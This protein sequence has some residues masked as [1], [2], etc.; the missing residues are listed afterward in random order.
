M[1]EFL[2]MLLTLLLALSPWAGRNG[3]DSTPPPSAAPVLTE[4]PAHTRTPAPTH[5]PAPM[6]APAPAPSPQP[7]GKPAATK[8]K[9]GPVDNIN[10]NTVLALDGAVYY[11][12]GGHGY[13]SVGLDGTELPFD[14]YYG[15]GLSTEGTLL[16]VTWH[17]YTEQDVRPTAVTMYSPY[18]NAEMPLG[19][20]SVEAG[21]TLSIDT[22]NVG[23]G[24]YELQI[25]W[26]NG[27]VT[28]LGFYKNGDELWYC[29]DA[30]ESSEYMCR[31]YDRKDAI[32]A[33]LAEQGVTPENSLDYSDD[34][35]AYPVPADY[36][37]GYRC[38]N[39]RWIG[40]AR[41]LA[42]DPSLPDA[43]KAILIHDWM[44]ENLAYDDYKVNCLGNTRA[45]VYKDYTG[46]YSM[47]DTKTGVCADFTTVY[48]IML[49]SLGIPAVSLDY[50]D[51]HV[52]NVVYLDGDWVEID[53]TDDIDRTVCGEDVTE[54]TNAG[55]TVDYDTFGA[56]YTIESIEPGKHNINHGIYTRAFVTRKGWY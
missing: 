25:A 14:V 54:V 44:V 53:L 37:K 31:W 49:R 38:D 26:S 51:E 32:D 13:A 56:P 12:F 23:T 29:R 42:G 5:T 10:G 3:G 22:A 18:L 28:A 27:S 36:G 46:K 6:P 20:M 16:N 7:S 24:P 4:A 52:W 55:D 41:E 40:L 30:E 48:C 45:A 11:G 19:E 34:R 50:N 2:S 47:W 21:E 1:K 43:Q 15:A 35:W 33:L 17:N 39:S 9:V 8:G